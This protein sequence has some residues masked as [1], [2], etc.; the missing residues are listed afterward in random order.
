MPENN[1]L[2][3][4]FKSWPSVAP[5]L[6]LVVVLWA[7]VNTSLKKDYRTGILESDAKGYYAYLPAVFIYHD[8]NFGFYNKIEIET[9]FNPNIYYDY[10]VVSNADTINR[11]Y[12]GTAVYLVPFFLA[13]H[14]IT[15]LSEF[16][17]D[18]YSYYYTMMVHLGAL[19]YLLLALLGLRKLL[20]S[21]RINENTIAIVLMAMVFGTNL[22]YYTVTEFG[23]SHLYSFTAIAWFCLTIRRYITDRKNQ[24]LLYSAILLGII[25]L[26]RPVNLLVVLAIP[27]LADDFDHLRSAANR[28]FSRWW[29]LLTALT[30]FIA[31]VSMQ[32][33][34]YKISTGSFFV[35]S[36]KSYGF[37]FLKPQIWN[38]LFS[39]RKGMFVYTPM[40]LLSLTGFIFL[41]RESRYRFYTLAG[42]LIVIIYVFSSWF[43]WYYGGSFSQRV[44]IEFYPFFALLLAIAIQAMKNRN[45]KK[46]FISLIILLVIVCQIQTYQY[47]RMQIHWSDMT[48]EKYWDVFMRIDKLK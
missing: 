32:F 17:A 20:R 42:F 23:M 4:T 14:A 24:Y 28:I 33:A 10:R 5:W 12:A 38:F 44:M 31:I 29:I 41:F 25:T 45:T 26:I 22:F 30:A 6:I 7:F 36:Y 9:Y 1:L 2:K 37:N 18:G 27:F 13:G 21:Y 19:V 39:Y 15:L 16:P 11:Y 46:I 40:L 35:D 43:L 34:I 3:S 48:K 8:L 47:R